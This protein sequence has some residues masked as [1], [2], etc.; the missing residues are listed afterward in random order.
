MTKHVTKCQFVGLETSFSIYSIMSVIQCLL[1]VLPS[2]GTRELIITTWKVVFMTHENFHLRGQE[3]DKRVAFKWALLVNT[4][5]TTPFEGTIT[6]W[7]NVGVPGNC[8][9]LCALILMKKP[10]LEESERN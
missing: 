6:S 4:V 5:Y 10:L 7:I 2:N 8:T 1:Y 3:Y 9:I